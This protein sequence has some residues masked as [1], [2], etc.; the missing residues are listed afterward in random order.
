MLSHSL[1]L[2]LFHAL[3]GRDPGKQIYLGRESPS[4]PDDSLWGQ[5]FGEG[6][7]RVRTTDSK[8]EI[9]AVGHHQQINKWINDVSV[10]IHFQSENEEWR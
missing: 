1:A 2:H 8:T 9:E 7:S 4:I 10:Q 5:H 3:H 6:S